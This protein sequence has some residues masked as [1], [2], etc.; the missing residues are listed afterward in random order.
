ML[1]TVYRKQLLRKMQETGLP[2][3]DAAKSYFRGRDFFGKLEGRPEDLK[4]ITATLKSPHFF[5]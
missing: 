2:L 3:A 1:P 4:L 5:G